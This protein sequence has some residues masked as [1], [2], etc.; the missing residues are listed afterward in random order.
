MNKHKLWVVESNGAPRSGK[1]TITSALTESYADAAQDE[2]GADYRAVT[3]G[4][5]E[6]GHLEEGQSDSDIERAVSKLDNRE[7]ADYAAMRYEIVAEQG[8]KVLYEPRINETV[9]KIGKIS[10]VRSAVKEGF[11]RRVQ[12]VIDNPDVNL[13]FVDGRNLGP[14]I[15]KIEG[16]ELG[17]R[18]FVDCQPAEAARRE[19]LRQGVDYQ[20]SSN[21]EWFMKTKASI[22]ARK[23]ADEQRTLD[24]VSKDED[25]IAYWHND[26][27]MTET[28]QYFART[29]GKSIGNMASILNTKFRID[30]RY[31]AGAKA[32][33]ESRQIYFDTSEIDKNAMINLSRR[34]VDEALQ[35]RAGIYTP[36]SDDLFR[37]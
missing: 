20:D 25:A 8:D 28:M 26:D 30:G 34:M 31:G 1:G 14:V 18:L 9:A 19:A 16:A 3:Y 35:E 29:R 13:L 22:K 12:R 24:P 27:V 17:L 15:E 4:L 33:H 6:N 2:T 23:L 7:I 11:T 5:L 21:D 32:V 36:R 37:I 10:V